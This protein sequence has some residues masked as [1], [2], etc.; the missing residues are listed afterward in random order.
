MSALILSTLFSFIACVNPD[1][2]KFL[3]VGKWNSGHS[4][5]NFVN[6]IID[7][8][9]NEKNEKIRFYPYFSFFFKKIITFGLSKTN[10]LHIN[11]LY[12]IIL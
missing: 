8:T 12:K 4:E 3:I 6:R 9:Y 2:N 10:N 5:L 1:S 11:N 7:Y